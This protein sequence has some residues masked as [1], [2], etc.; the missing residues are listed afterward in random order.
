MRLGTNPSLSSLLLF[1]YGVGA[2]W[3]LSSCLTGLGSG[4]GCIAVHM[5]W[6][7]FT[8]LSPTKWFTFFPPFLPEH[9]KFSLVFNSFAAFL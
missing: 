9:E 7:V 2:E 1:F 3:D 8:D 4:L 6:Y 5:N